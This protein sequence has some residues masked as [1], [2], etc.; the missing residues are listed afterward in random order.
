MK[1]L[2]TLITGVHV[3]SLVFL[4]DKTLIGFETLQNL[5]E[6]DA[7]FAVQKEGRKS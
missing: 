3:L 6:A 1:L 5:L 2:K 4:C 7:K